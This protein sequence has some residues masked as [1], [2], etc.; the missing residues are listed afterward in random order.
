MNHRIAVLALALIAASA[1]SA[2]EG[3]RRF[4][5]PANDGY[6]LAD[7]LEA[8]SSCGGVVANAWCEAKGYRAAVAFGRADPAD[9]TATLVGTSR[10]RAPVYVVT[11]MK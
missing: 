11:C 5:I 7:C 1:A 8:G 3:E 2:A 9:M 10:G 4:L 6:G